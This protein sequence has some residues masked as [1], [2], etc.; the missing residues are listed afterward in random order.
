MID[1][2]TYSKIVHNGSYFAVYPTEDSKDRIKE[3]AR[4]CGIF[5]DVDE[6]HVTVMY[7][8]DVGTPDID[9]KSN[10]VYTANC[11]EFRLFG[12]RSDY[13]VVELDCPELESRHY[14]LR[15]YGLEHT[16]AKYRPHLTLAEGFHGDLPDFSKF[17]VGVIT[18]TG[19]THSACRT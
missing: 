10:I 15:E 3:A 17:D 8:P 4:K 5:V 9:A 16:F 12:E 11:T 18:L 1:F 19:E 6:L 7:S 14:E 13:L 2:N